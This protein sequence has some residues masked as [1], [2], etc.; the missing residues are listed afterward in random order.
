MCGRIYDAG[1]APYLPGVALALRIGVSTPC[2]EV[3]TRGTTVFVPGSLKLYIYGRI[4]DRGVVS[5]PPR[6]ALALQTP[7]WGFHTVR[8]GIDPG[9]HRVRLQLLELNMYGRIYGPGMGLYPARVALALRT[10]GWGFHH[11][12]G[13]I[14][15]GDHL[16]RPRF[17]GV[18][19]VWK[20][21]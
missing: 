7:Y 20:D 21:L 4:S 18:V 15:P 16:C 14:D 8:G 2:M 11:V 5:Y 17:V 19:D 9:D 12:R 13:G 6:V 3:S 1:M 10:P